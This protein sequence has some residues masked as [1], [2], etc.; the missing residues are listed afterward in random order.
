MTTSLLGTHLLLRGKQCEKHQR[1]LLLLETLHNRK[2]D[3]AKVDCNVPAD[4]QKEH[5]GRLHGNTGTLTL[6][7]K[8]TKLD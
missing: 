3:V 4:L 1:L 2:R 6:A 7:Q 5:T 8:A